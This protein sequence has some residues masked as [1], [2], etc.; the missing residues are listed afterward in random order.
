MK[1]KCII[2]KIIYFF[3]I[4]SNLSFIYISEDWINDCYK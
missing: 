1:L 4:V 2:K 3:Y